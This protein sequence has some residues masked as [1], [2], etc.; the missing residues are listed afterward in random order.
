MN[1]IALPIAVRQ[2]RRPR[3]REKLLQDGRTSTM[4]TGHFVQVLDTCLEPVSRFQ[5]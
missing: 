2:V 4:D 3:V 5:F 1:T